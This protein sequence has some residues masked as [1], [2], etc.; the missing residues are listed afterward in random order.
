MNSIDKNILDSN[1]QEDHD[2]LS[3]L[4]VQNLS[5]DNLNPKLSWW[6]LPKRIVACIYRLICLCILLAIAASIPILQWA[7]LGYLLEV[8]SRMAKRR[9]WR[10]SYLG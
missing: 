8:A 3:N 6:S 2:R 1:I 10:E 7:S 4:S 9:P 5:V